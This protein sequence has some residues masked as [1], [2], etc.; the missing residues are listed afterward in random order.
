MGLLFY[1]VGLLNAFVVWSCIDSGK[2]D[3]I[4]TAIICGIIAALCFM[5]GAAYE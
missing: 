4:P 3:N 2:P 5:R 1:F